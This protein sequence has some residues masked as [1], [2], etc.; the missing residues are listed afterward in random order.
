MPR[1]T[2]LSDEEIE[3]IVNW[4]ERKKSSGWIAVKMNLP[5]GTVNYQLLLAG[6]DPFD[7][8]KSSGRNPGAFTPD[9]DAKLLALAQDGKKLPTIAAE[10]KRPRSSVRLRWMLLEIRAEKALE[11][12]A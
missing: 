10:M 7:S 12:A 2:R 5:K 9:E 3:A 1:G 4:R 6:L 11:D 8:P